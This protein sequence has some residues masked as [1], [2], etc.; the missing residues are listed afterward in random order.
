M[1]RVK[2][3]LR[4]EDFEALAPGVEAFLPRSNDRTARLVLQAMLREGMLECCRREWDGKLLTLRGPDV[5][6][7]VA[8]RWAG[9]G[10]RFFTT[11][12]MPELGSFLEK[13][14]RLAGL[15]ETP[16]WA[17]FVEEMTQATLTQAVAYQ[18]ADQRPEPRD[19]LDFEA[20]TPEGHNL[21]PG[22]KTRAGFGASDQLL[23][24]PELA[25]IIELPWLAV[26]KE[27]LQQAGEVDP[28]FEL[29]D[30]EWAIPVHPWQL[31]RVLPELYGR[32]MGRGLIRPLDREPVVCRLCTSLRTVV[33]LDQSLPTLKTS[34][35]SLMTST[36]RS[37]SRFTV[38][39]GP[40]YSEYLRQIFERENFGE[41]VLAL[42]E[43]GGFCWREDQ[44]ERRA[45]NLSLL[46]RQRAPRLEQ[47]MAVP[48][49]TLTQP[50]WRDPSRT[51]FYH[52]F[53]QGQGPLHNFDRYLELMVPFHLELYLRHG[54][55]LE[56]HLQNCVVVWDEQGP[57][58]LWVRDWGGLR[59]DAEKLQR[60]AP[61]VLARLDQRSVSLST[62]VA[63]ERKLIACLYCNHLTEVVAGVSLAF[64]L[65]EEELW[66][67]VARI[68]D[69]VFR[70]N[71]G[72]ELEEQVLRQPWPVKCLLKMRMA[73]KSSGDLYGM[74][75][76]PLKSHLSA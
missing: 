75:E 30:R 1:P 68:S 14:G 34:V 24:A 60:L 65:P 53:G 50:V 69:R 43:F 20:W 42:D 8:G 22:A 21:H 67:R 18:R 58:R 76:N 41:A 51:Y 63:A 19:Y 48:S 4:L 44:D 23:Y 26:N 10:D 55:A 6:L 49:S 9:N 25:D 35:G 46:F 38:L 56:A 66:A 36:E 64:D 45:R 11:S 37:M 71:S 15:G 13:L 62:A 47:G 32:E 33:P 74:K 17:D 12:G 2:E 61:D 3:A 54:L 16:A 40:V 7:I 52:L 59:A 72:S 57:A 28:I 70:D 39:Q 31:A 73:P 27:L 5:E 29:D